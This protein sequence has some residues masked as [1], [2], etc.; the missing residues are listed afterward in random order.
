M[1]ICHAIC[2]NVLAYVRSANEAAVI[3]KVLAVFLFFIL[4]H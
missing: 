3:K 2:R 4:V 1:L